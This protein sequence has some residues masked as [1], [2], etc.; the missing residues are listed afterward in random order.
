M[1]PCLPKARLALFLGTCL[2]LVPLDRMG[3]VFL[4]TLK[5]RPVSAPGQGYML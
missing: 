1:A 2:A 5:T 4:L 3:L